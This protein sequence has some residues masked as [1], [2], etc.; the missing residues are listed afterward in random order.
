MSITITVIIDLLLPVE[1]KDFWSGQNGILDN[2]LTYDQSGDIQIFHCNIVLIL[3]YY[4]TTYGLYESFFF[5]YT[6]DK[7]R[8][9]CIIGKS[10]KKLDSVINF[11]ALMPY[12]HA[13][14]Y[15]IKYDMDCTQAK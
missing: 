7:I 3:L 1:K 2:Y 5:V 8:P 10:N 9:L 14:W 11:D 4:T 6:F 13:D 12:G 15:S